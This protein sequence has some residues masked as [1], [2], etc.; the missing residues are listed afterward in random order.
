MRFDIEIDGTQD[1]MCGMAPKLTEVLDANEAFGKLTETE[2]SKIRNIGNYSTYA[3]HR[4]INPMVDL[5]HKLTRLKFK[6]YAGD[7]KACDIEIK[8]IKVKSKTRLKLTAATYND[9]ET[10]TLKHNIDLTT[11]DGD[12]PSANW[13]WCTLRG[14]WTEEGECP[15]A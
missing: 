8:Y 13:G 12:T 1:V 5:K 3:A 14:T 6:A 15:K 2:K 4:N 7:Q 10:G 9:K 11:C